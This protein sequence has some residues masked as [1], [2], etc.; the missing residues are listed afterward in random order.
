MITKIAS[1][2][3][4][5][6]W[7]EDTFT[8]RS[9]IHHT[10]AVSRDGARIAYVIVANDAKRCEI[11]IRDVRT[12]RDTTLAYVAESYR[13][14]AW[15]SDDAEIAYEG[16]SGITAVSAVRGDERVVARGPLRI[17][18]VPISGGYFLQS[19]DWLHD[20]SELVVDASICVPTGEPD[21]CQHTNT[22]WVGV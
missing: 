19:V 6:S 5:H 14:R 18:G 13:M 11:V 10:A 12:D 3:A 16:P 2:S 15:S 21:T 8:V 7:V 17:N 9:V 20:Q 4:D 1:K 22:R